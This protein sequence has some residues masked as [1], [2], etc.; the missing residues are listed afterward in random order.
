MIHVVG[1]VALFTSHTYRFLNFKI[2][3]MD[4]LVEISFDEGLQEVRREV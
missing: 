1:G 3:K 2:K 4:Q